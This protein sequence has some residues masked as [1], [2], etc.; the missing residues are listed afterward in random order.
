MQ[1]LIDEHYQTT[2]RQRENLERPMYDREEHAR[3]HA[4]RLAAQEEADHATVSPEA[5]RMAAE[6]GHRLV[7]MP[8]ELGGEHLD[9]GDPGDAD[10]FVQ[11]FRDWLVSAKH[12]QRV[13][14][15]FFEHVAP[16][17]TS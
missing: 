14:F 5:A 10:L 13:S 11:G 9:L 2:A 16:E 1:S 8:E 3:I 6:R 17:E 4:D 12:G 7:K 15:G